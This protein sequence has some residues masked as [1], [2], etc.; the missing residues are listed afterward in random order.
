MRTA[1]YI[2]RQ[3]YAV[4]I[5]AA[6]LVALFF[7]SKATANEVDLGTIKAMPV[8]DL[9]RK[10]DDTPVTYIDTGEIVDP[11]TGELARGPHQI[12][13]SVA[14][15]SP[16]GLVINGNTVLPGSTHTFTFNLTNLGHRLYMPVYPDKDFVDGDADFFL[17]IPFV[18][19][20]ACPPKFEERTGDCY[21]L[22]F[23][24][25]THICPNG[26]F[27][28]GNGTCRRNQPLELTTSCP[29]GF[30][31]LS[32]DRC[33]RTFTVNAYTYCSGEDFYITDGECVKRDY[34]R[35]QTCPDNYVHMDN[36]CHSETSNDVKPVG[37][38]CPE[39]TT[40]HEEKR[41]C[42][43]LTKDEIRY[44][45]PSGFSRDNTVCSRKET[46][47]MDISCRDTYTRDGDNCWYFESWHAETSCASGWEKNGYVCDYYREANIQSCPSGYVKHNNVCHK[48]R[49]KWQ[50]C[51][52]G[53]VNTG[54]R[55]EKY[56]KTNIQSCP[57]GFRLV[58]N[59]CRQVDAAEPVC[60]SG[61]SWISSRN[62]CEQFQEIDATPV[63]QS[64]Y[65]WNATN[66][67]CERTESKNA[68]PVCPAN[69]SYSSA[70]DRCEKVES[71]SASKV[72]A[73]GYSYVSSRDRCEKTETR[74][75]NQSCPS[76]FTK[77]GNQCVRTL[78]ESPVY[79]C[80]EGVPVGLKC[81]VEHI[82]NQTYR[83]P[84]GTGLYD[85]WHE[86][87]NNPNRCFQIQK[88][89]FNAFSMGE[90][91]TECKDSSWSG[92]YWDILYKDHYCTKKTYK[93]K[94]WQCGPNAQ[95]LP[96][97]KC[98]GTKKVSMEMICPTEGYT[99]DKSQ[100]KCVKTEA[101]A[102]SQS[103]PSGWSLSGGSCKRTLTA[104]YSYTCSSGWKLSGSQCKRTLTSQES[105]SCPSGW[106]LSGR[107]CG[108]LLTAGPSSYSCPAATPSWSVSGSDCQ[109]TV[110]QTPGW[111]C[112]SNETRFNTNKCYSNTASSGVGNCPSASPS[113]NINGTFC[114]RTLTDNINYYC[115]SGWEGHNTSL[116][117]EVDYSPNVGNC[118]TNYELRTNIC[119][120]ERQKEVTWTCPATH[121]LKKP[122]CEYYDEEPVIV[123]CP[124]ADGFQ[125]NGSACQKVIKED[126]VYYCPD[127]YMPTNDFSKCYRETEVPK[128]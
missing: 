40:Y 90:D 8:S 11:N 116:C 1:L 26:F 123:E 122:N 106:S 91:Q 23:T 3:P 114:D 50:S 31:K 72:C 39:G 63:C 127:R 42:E 125:P 6:A 54:T 21:K 88:D 109:R 111:R 15:E 98:K 47:K 84:G 108:R 28:E 20:E 110:H 118:Q 103:C 14:A 121:T 83:C 120:D 4:L 99:H 126:V 30:S 78:E 77:S 56:E 74:T 73:S 71:K 69:Y 66:D 95:K 22:E 57:S 87:P 29:A 9:M 59:T 96:G 107:K 44:S 24:P 115:A 7:A 35:S 27:Y 75:V 97:R 81:E 93:S 104:S 82:Y 128:L 62:R 102:V 64:G 112:D 33:S 45:C 100:N 49:N 55:C 18:S 38:Y 61:F 12:T 58:N 43:K 52:T 46:F 70:N 10:Q 16:F 2:L 37:N 76:G 19:A 113:W 124:V 80:A 25:I 34:S 51:P 5:F 32:G 13:F 48:A 67:R 101:R 36:A 85:I 119:V 117:R 53:Y 68:T 94:S 92:P 17:S 60:P 41:S 89:Y 79:G 65:S 86:D 105:W